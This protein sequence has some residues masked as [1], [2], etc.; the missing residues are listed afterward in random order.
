[1]QLR[2]RYEQLCLVG[3][4][5]FEKLHVALAQV[6]VHQTSIT[7]D[8]VLFVHYR[9]TDLQFGEVAQPVVQRGLALCRVTTPPRGAPGVEFGLGNEGPLIGLRGTRCIRRQEKAVVQRR[10]AQR[11]SALADEEFAKIGAGIGFQAIV[12]EECGKGFAASGRFCQQQHAAGKAGD[13]SLQSAQRIVG[14]AGDGD[15]RCG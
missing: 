10:D 9:I 8:A 4:V 11:Q 13:K 2:D 15:W 7:R 6:K 3:V 12:G 5:E 1:M 14:T